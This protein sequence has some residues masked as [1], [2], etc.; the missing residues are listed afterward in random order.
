MGG[1]ASVPAEVANRLTTASLEFGLTQARRSGVVLA[2]RW[3]QDWRSSP[4]SSRYLV[5]AAG[6]PI[7]HGDLVMK[8]EDG[9]LYRATPGELPPM[10]SKS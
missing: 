6:E 3:P 4:P 10:V 2:A 5:G 1:I 8:G 7:E 9:L